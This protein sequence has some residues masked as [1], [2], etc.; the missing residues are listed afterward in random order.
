[1]ARLLWMSGAMEGA[2]TAE[3]W[4]SLAHLA[5]AEEL[6]TQQQAFFRMGNLAR[7]SHGCS[8]NVEAQPRAYVPPSDAARERRLISRP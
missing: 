6:G 5:W 7:T 1:V 8:S 2:S 3:R 4:R